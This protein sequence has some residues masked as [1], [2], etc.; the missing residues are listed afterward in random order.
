[1]A[2]KPK[3]VE[4]RKLTPR[5]RAFVEEYLTDLNAMAAYIRAGF[6]AKGADHHAH[7]L[8]RAPHVAAAVAEA[9]EVRSKRV[10]VT[11]DMVLERWWKIA[12]ADPRELT[13]YR[14]TACRY[15]YGEGHDFQWI[16]EVEFQA[17]VADAVE[18]KKPAPRKAGGFGYVEIADAHPQCPRCN[19][20]GIGRA[21]G[22]DTR[23]LS[24][25]ASLLFDGVKETRDGVEIKTLDRMKAF[26]NV[27]RHLGMFVD[28]VEHTS[29]D[30]SM[31]PLPPV[32]NITGT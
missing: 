12:T 5:Q 24:A 29:P 8:L 18:R 17:A 15:C 26:E 2:V 21:H 22:K 4:P 31:T 16:D 6:S 13:Q 20:E 3:A 19:G 1:M 28:K 7:E 32:Y 9:M 27:A 14:R 30:G 23:H 25:S 11:A 10:A